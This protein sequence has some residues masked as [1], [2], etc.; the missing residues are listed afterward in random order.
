MMKKIFLAAMAIAL[1]AS[2]SKS[3]VEE[4]NNL[5]LSGEAV[6]SLNVA[7]PK[8][9]TKNEGPHNEDYSRLDAIRGLDIFVFKEDGSLDTYLKVPSNKTAIKD[10]LANIK[11]SV[12][13]GVRSIYA[14]A[15]S[16]VDNWQG[17]TTYEKFSKMSANLSNENFDNFTM[18]GNVTQTIESSKNITINLERLVAR[19]VVKS[20]ATAFD[21]TPF[22]GYSLDFAKLYLVNVVGNKS[23]IGEEVLPK[24][25]LNYKGYKE[26]DCQ[27]LGMTAC[28]Y[29]SI[30]NR[31]DDSNPYIHSHYFYCYANTLQNETNSERFTRLVL[32][33]SINGKKYYYPININREGFGWNSSIDHKGIK[34]N[35]SYEFNIVISRLGV[36]SPDKALDLKSVTLSAVV[37][38]WGRASSFD[39]NF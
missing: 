28:L 38:D 26:S 31:I 21:K 25:I 23:F 24:Q 30:S 2:C 27:S 7:T 39:L 8:V 37:D 14:V 9:S 15:N 10:S 6:L 4:G 36:D 3:D 20:V 5:P 32:E 35:T 22:D 11:I 1:L 17:V 16:K 33:A 34:N 19:V 13:P 18:I 12:T 29:E